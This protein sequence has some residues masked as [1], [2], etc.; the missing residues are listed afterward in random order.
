MRVVVSIGGSVLAPDL[1]PDRVKG[2]ARV[3]DSLVESGHE[4]AAVVGGGDV[5]RKYIG[6]A[7]ELGATEYDLDTL[8]I[9]VTRLN[10]RLLL[11][12]LESSAIPEPADDPET[13]RASLRRGEVAVMGGT[14]PGHT[15]DAVS[16]LLAETVEADLLIYATSVAGVGLVGVRRVDAGDARRVDQQ[17]R[18]DGLREQRRDGVGGVARH[19]PAHDGDLAAPEGRPCGLG[20]VG[21]FRNRRRR[22]RRQEQPGV[23]PRHV[24]AQGVEVVLRGAEFAGSPDVPA[25]GVAA[26]HDGGDLVAG[27]DQR[28]DDAGLSPDPVGF[29]VRREHA[30]TDRNDDSHWLSIALFRY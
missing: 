25:G 12:A 4:V 30:P 22:K 3:I 14:V 7:R 17:V 5:A 23:Q 10:A 8:G 27:L 11:T 13:A 24:D 21:G 26:P 18:F 15:T 28:V 20:V 6:T 16:A 19:G 2:H 1:E 29:E 9:D